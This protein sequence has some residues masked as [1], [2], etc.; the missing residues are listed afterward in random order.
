[1]DKNS[2]LPLHIGQRES[3]VRDIDPPTFQ[4]GFDFAIVALGFSLRCSVSLFIL[5]G[6]RNPTCATGKR[7]KSIPPKVGGDEGRRYPT[8]NQRN[9]LK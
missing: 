2:L 1:M 4:L 8:E 3:R 9:Q 7:T 5:H 6:F